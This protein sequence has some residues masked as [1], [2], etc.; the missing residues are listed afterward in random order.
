[1]QFWNSQISSVVFPKDARPKYNMASR[2][3]NRTLLFYMLLSER[4]GDGCSWISVE[5][6][7]GMMCLTE[8][9]LLHASASDGALNHAK[10]TLAA[11]TQVVVP[12][13]VYSRFVRLE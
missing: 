3:I 4:L 2:T 7:S 12:E 13:R 8:I 9:P 6:Y 5:T 10:A 11:S 1:M